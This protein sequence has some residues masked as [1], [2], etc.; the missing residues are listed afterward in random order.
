ME[1]FIAQGKQRCKLQCKHEDS[2]PKI[3]F[4]IY[5]KYRIL[6]SLT[7]TVTYSSCKLLSKF[8]LVGQHELYFLRIANQYL[9]ILLQCFCTVTSDSYTTAFVLTTLHD[10]THALRPCSTTSTTVAPTDHCYLMDN[11]SRRWL[12]IKDAAL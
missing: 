12:P 1:F 10:C 8:H 4:L 11:I 9:L 6:C 7:K 5:T 3:P 2:P